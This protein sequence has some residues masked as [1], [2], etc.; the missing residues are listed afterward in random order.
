VTGT[1][2]KRW[3][4]A[5]LTA[6]SAVLAALALAGCGGQ[7]QAARPRIDSE[8]ARRLAD[9]SDEV[10]RLLDDHRDCEAAHAAD[11]LQ[12]QAEA[13]VDAGTVPPA[14]AHELSA[15]ATELVNEVNC[16]EPPPPPEEGDE[17]KGKPKKGKGHGKEGKEE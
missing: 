16:P 6:C 13:A 12:G 11:R 3:Q 4:N 7:E 8:T 2:Q 10:A 14:L 17:D 15:R 1:F 5:W 9:R